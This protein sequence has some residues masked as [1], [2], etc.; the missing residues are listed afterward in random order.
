MLHVTICC[1]LYKLSLATILAFS[2]PFA[3]LSK[4]ANM[5]R[6]GSR[7]RHISVNWQDIGQLASE[8]NGVLYP[9]PLC[10]LQALISIDQ[11]VQH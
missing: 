4:K 2:Q 5:I 3:S 11:Y 7:R 10:G 8:V 9:F 1:K 6:S